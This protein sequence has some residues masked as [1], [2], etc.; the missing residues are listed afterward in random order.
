[1][2]TYGYARVSTNGQ[3]LGSQEAE[4]LAAGCARV[5]KEKVSGAKADRAELGKLVKRLEPD[6]VLVVTRLD[7][8][9]ICSTSS[10]P[11]AK[12]RL[13]SA[14]SKIPGPTPQHRTAGS[15]LRFLAVSLSSSASSSAPAQAKA[16]SALRHVA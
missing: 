13:A 5:F 14:A 16:G 1:M 12:A 3:D 10:P 11:S 4:L 9:A 6:D 7:R 2:A 8:L 15:C